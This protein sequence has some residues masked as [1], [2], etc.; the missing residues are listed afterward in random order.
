MQF[1]LPEEIGALAQSIDGFARAELAP[2][3]AERALR[4]AFP[5]DVM[6]LFAAWGLNGIV[7]GSN[8]EGR[9]RGVLAGTVA[10]E[11][12]ARVCPRGAD[13]LHHGNF[14][15]ALLLARYAD[16]TCKDELDQI[17]AGNRL[18]TIAVT[19]EQAGSQASALETRARVAGDH[20][21]V[22]GGKRF[23]TNSAEADAFVIYVRFG[24]DIGAVIVDGKS[25]GLSRGEPVAFM[26]GDRWCS[27]TFN[28][29]A[30]PQ[31]AALFRTGGFSVKGSFFD[32]EKIGNAARAL[33][34]GWCAFDAVREYAANRRQFGK[35]LSEFQGLQWRLAEARLALEAAQL[36]LYRVASRADHNMLRG[37]DA[38]C[39]KLICN[40]AAMT[41]CDTA[42]QILGGA[43]YSQGNL[44][45]Y[46]FRKV[47]GQ[48]ITGGVVELMLTRVAEAI[49][50]RKFPQDAR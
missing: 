14:S 46:C 23:A 18:V 17:L 9:P 24:E 13:A 26:S 19:E 7:V 5:R 20:I 42:V 39:A 47:R 30:V 29:V 15:A 40:R 6:K 27:L 10:V 32:L 50:D 8:D 11:A 28:E 33:G 31:P 34:T 2:G 37:E 1:E 21:I 48:L 41:A 43:G 36:T 45:E 22:D 16:G 38:T 49:F 4:S 25:R 3:A 35:T 12:V 44:V